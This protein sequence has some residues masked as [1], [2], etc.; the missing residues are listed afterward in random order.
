MSLSNGHVLLEPVAIRPLW[1]GSWLKQT[2][3]LKTAG[4][5]LT[6]K[7]N[8]KAAD[9]VIGAIALLSK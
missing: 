5:V 3:N 6:Y 4:V 8:Q 9:V 1:K 2:P 7:S